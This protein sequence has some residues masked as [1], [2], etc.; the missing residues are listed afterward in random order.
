[1]RGEALISQGKKIETALWLSGL[2]CISVYGLTRIQS[3][4]ARS[5]AISA[6][7]AQWPLTALDRDLKKLEDTLDKL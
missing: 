4:R 1:M 7:E 3:A 5:A 2:D 6:L